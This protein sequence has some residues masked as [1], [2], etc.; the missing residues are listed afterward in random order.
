MC[1]LLFLSFCSLS[2]RYAVSLAGGRG[3]MLPLL[4]H[5]LYSNNNIWRV[6]SGCVPQ[7]KPRRMT[8]E[9]SLAHVTRLHLRVII[10]VYARL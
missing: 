2:V 3:M 8:N 1:R 6:T 9:L 4:S 10:G 5:T 7:H